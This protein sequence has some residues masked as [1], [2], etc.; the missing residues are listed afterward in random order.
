[1]SVFLSVY[2]KLFIGIYFLVV[3]VVG[4]LAARKETKEGFLIADRRLG[5][6]SAVATLTASKIGSLIL[7]T[8]LAFVY[9]FGISAMWFFIGQVVGL[10]LFYFFAKTLKT[11]AD[12]EKYYTLTDFFQTKFGK[13]SG[14]LTAI[15]T[16][17]M[18]FIYFG[19]GL[20]GASQILVSLT[21]FSYLT[22]LL[23]IGLTIMIYLSAAGFKGVVATDILQ[24]ISIIVLFIIILA[25][26]GGNFEYHPEQWQIIGVGLKDVTS[27]FLAGM[28][29]PFALT[30]MWQRVYAVKNRKTLKKSF[31]FTVFSYLII[32]FIIS[33]IGIIIKT[34]VPGINPDMALVEGFKRLLPPN[35]M[36][37][38]A[39]TA[40][41]A[42][43]MSSSDTSFFTG[44]VVI[45]QD[46]IGKRRKLSKDE[47]VKTL[48]WV[49]AVCVVIGM[50]LAY[51]VPSMIKLAIAQFAFISVL[52]IVVFVV[53]IFKKV[54]KF[55]I[56]FALTVGLLIVLIISIY[57]I[58][59][60][61]I[62]TIVV[63]F[64]IIATILSIIL[65]RLIL[66]VR[67][68]LGKRN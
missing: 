29:V 3:I 21:G 37:G 39:V 64:A 51:F 41:F 10:I 67:E 65:G 44:A 59:Q 33:L 27:F 45:V 55:I 6:F 46:F 58:L 47:I 48:R 43:V 13:T 4:V 36:M 15:I 68:G 23:L 9:T 30:E 18:Y 53:W 28:L 25:F 12:E 32:G 60:G 40:L 16:L 19:L 31:I 34:K 7:I 26:I 54:D 22:S 14:T 35:G 24:Y 57:Y 1:M 61:E 56:N 8:Y 2:D 63:I 17:L 50:A 5:V 52:S 62:N 11:E 66:M 38:I 42:A 20:V 49:I